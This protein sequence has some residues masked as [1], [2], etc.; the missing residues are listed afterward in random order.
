MTAGEQSSGRDIK[1]LCRKIIRDEYKM[2][3]LSSGLVVGA[4]FYAIVRSQVGARRM[5]RA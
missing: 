1:K 3:L 5:R 2:V 4:P